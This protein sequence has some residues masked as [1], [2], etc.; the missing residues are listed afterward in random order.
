MPSLPASVTTERPLLAGHPVATVEQREH[1]LAALE[2]VAHP[3][4]KAAY[5]SVAATW[6]G[7]AKASS[8]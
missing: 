8:A 2:L 3:T 4:V 5:A 6:L 7:R 1:E